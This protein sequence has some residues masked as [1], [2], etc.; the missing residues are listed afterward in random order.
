MRAERGQRVGRNE[1][2]PC[3]NGKKYKHCH[4]DPARTEPFLR[5]GFEEE[6]RRV[7]AENEA[8]EAR[9]TAQQ[10]QGRPIISLETPQHRLIAVGNQMHWGNWKTFFDFL[11]PYLITVLGAE[12]GNAELAKPLVDRHPIL[13]WYDA[14][15]TIQRRNIKEPGKIQAMRMTGATALWYGL[16]YSLYLLRHNAEVQA[17]LVRRLKHPDQF[18][19]AYYET[20]VAGWFILAGFELEL[21]DAADGSGTHVEFTA[22]SKSTGKMFSVEAK[23]RGPNKGHLDVGNQLVKA[24]R[25]TAAHPRIV[26]IDVN[27]PHDPQRTAE[28]WRRSVASSVRGRESILID[29]QPAPPA[30]VLVTNHPFAYDLEGSETPQ[31]VVAEGFNIADFGGSVGYPNY[32]KAF[33]AQQRHIDLFRLAKAIAH[34]T[35]PTTFDG[36][37]PEI[38]FGQAERK[39]KIG[40]RYD[41]G[42]QGTGTLMAASVAEERKEVMLTFQTDTAGVAMARVPMTDAELS[43]YRSHP[44]TFFGVIRPVGSLKSEMD[45]FEW[46]HDSLKDS[47]RAQHLAFFKDSPELAR[48]SA[49]SDEDLLLE[50]CQSMTYAVALKPT[51]AR[52]S[53]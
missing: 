29:G 27:V 42:G 51:P 5:P 38:A 1:P 20:L 6:I 2:C 33:K 39:W 31:V 13:K 52:S 17:R 23:G 26:L 43:A 25:K 22:T 8:A 49:L 37:V 11:T 47:T 40:E 44:E 3:G 32:V 35:I 53:G 15:C 41:L 45:L 21:E 16:A 18:Q 24:L 10:G 19:G 48:L 7:M 46:F 14:L 9:R 4:G 28:D 30:Y 50:R 34:F 36:E 12:W